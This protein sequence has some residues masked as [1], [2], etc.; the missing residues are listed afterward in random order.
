MSTYDPSQIEPKWQAEWEKAHLF[1]TPEPGPSAPKYYDLVMFP[2]PSGN[3][4]MGHVRNYA[5]GDV[6]ARFKRMK[7]F[8]VLHPIGWDAFGMPAENAAIKNQTHPEPWTDNCIAR[9]TKQLKRLGISYDW[10]REVNTSKPA[11]Y[12]WTQWMFLLMYERGLAYRKKATVNWCPKCN[13]VLANE[14]VIK[15][16]SCW[17]CDTK[18]EQRELEQWFFKITE[19]ADRLLSDLDKLKGWPEPVKLM[20]RNW[21]GKSEGVEIEFVIDSPNLSVVNKLTIYTTRPDTLFGVTYMVLAPEHPLV[22]ELSKGTPQEQPVREY[23]EKV[24]H[25][26]THERAIKAAKDGVFTG[27]YAVNPATGEKVPIWTSD[28]VLME[29]GTGAV[30]AVPAHDQRDFEFAKQ[31]DLP[32]K[33]VI[34]PGSLTMDP[35]T[36]DHAFEMKEPWSAQ[37]S[38]TG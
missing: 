28:Y 19:Y 7:G 21:I 23:I 34:T 38:L 3:L 9:M 18:V 4:H 24:K 30:M 11:Y 10:E 6:I 27:G 32:I 15:E 8:S 26:S 17:R 35:S 16:E 14:Q 22:L 31:N 37:N 13:T 12:K 5:I 1:L 33:I 2:Y 20:Q 25:E 29:Y 36:L